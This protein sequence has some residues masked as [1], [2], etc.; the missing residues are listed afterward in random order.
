MCGIS[1]FIDFN[2]ASSIEILK[3]MA[4]VQINRGPDDS[5]YELFESSEAQIGLGFRRLSIIDLTPQGHQPMFSHDHSCCIV[6]NGE[7][8]N[9]KEIR[10][11]LEALG[12][13]FTTHSDT[14]VILQAYNQW[15]TACVERF[16][17]MFAF[18]IYDKKNQ[19][20]L[21][22]RDRVGVKP[23]F[24]Y[25]ANNI[26]LFASELKSFHQHP[27]FQKEIDT[28]A[29]SLYFQHGYISA[30]Y[31]IFKDAYKLMPGHFLAFNLVN[32]E[33]TTH[34]YWD[35]VDV[36]NQPKID[37]S[38]EEASKETERIFESA[39]QYR[40]IADVPVGVF[41]SGG[42]D[43]STLAAM[44]QKNNPQKIKTFTIGFQE[45]KYN[46]AHYAKE[47]AQHLGT[48][49]HEYYCTFKE[50]IAIVP[51]LPE[52]YDEPFGDSSAIPTTLVSKIARQSVTVALSADGGDEIFAGYPK[53]TRSLKFLPYRKMLPNALAK[54]ADKI[55][56][57]NHGVHFFGDIYT[58]GK[59][60]LRHSDPVSFFN[61]MATVM[62]YKQTQDLIKNN[63]PYLQTPFDQG[64]LLNATND[65]LAQMQ[66]VDFNTYLVD[67][68][69]Q[70]VDRATM[71]VSLEGR[72]PFIDQRIIE[73]V[74]TLPSSY[75][76]SQ[77]KTKYLLR[78][79]THKYLPAAMMERPKM[80]FQVPVTEWC[81]NELRSTL[82]YYTDK[83]KIRKQGL[84][85][86]QVTSELV[87]A[88]LAGRRVNFQKIWFL[89]MF[90]MWHERWMQ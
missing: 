68:I 83:E 24:Y 40:M 60:L 45:D 14:E 79:I 37:V 25:Q 17:G 65:D 22:F 13:S 48:E 80:G 15:G 74:A 50:A 19:K 82:L 23:L 16:I 56:P 46:E 87:G 52:S 27:S 71:S 36:Y 7:I 44:L 53:Y 26:L 61:D 86:P 3:K 5:G 9:Y 54:L 63:F 31:C 77:G 6:F 59:L 12:R 62:T 20:V 4:D 43:S 32:K 29:L 81:S 88:Y 57:D 10:K 42:Y 69:L 11:D 78:S 66:A 67:D 76:F 51:S 2:S 21:L 1:G 35:I 55:L 41:L 85:D 72:E 84:L 39:F 34:K 90:Q 49:H 89:L 18:S 33:L 64:H 58:K 30:P 75:K 28:A 38:F 47:V 73:Y 8:Y 70:K